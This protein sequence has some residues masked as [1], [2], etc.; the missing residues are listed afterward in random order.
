MD[1]LMIQ[2]TGVD[3]EGIQNISDVIIKTYDIF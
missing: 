3:D 2:G 1:S